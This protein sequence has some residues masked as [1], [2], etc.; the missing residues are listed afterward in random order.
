MQ[1]FG[2][3]FFAAKYT[4]LLIYLET[5]VDHNIWIYIVH[6]FSYRFMPLQIKVSGSIKSLSKSTTYIYMSFLVYTNTLTDMLKF[7]NLVLR[8]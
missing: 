5:D 8:N 7:V 2:V 6:L 3:P 4:V 1:S